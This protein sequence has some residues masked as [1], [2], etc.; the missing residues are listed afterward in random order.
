VHRPINL[1]P[2][3][4]AARGEG[5]GGFTPAHRAYFFGREIGW[6]RWNGRLASLS[7]EAGRD[8]EPGE[9][10]VPGALSGCRWR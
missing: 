2:V 7:G 9:A 10:R 8:P 6:N 5:F 4:R 3:V 1:L